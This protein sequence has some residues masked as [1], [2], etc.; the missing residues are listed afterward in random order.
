[1]YVGCTLP[2]ISLNSPRSL[3]PF[4][5]IPRR[6]SVKVEVV[7][8]I[9]QSLSLISLSSGPI[10]SFNVSLTGLMLVELSTT[11]SI[12]NFFTST[13]TGKTS[14]PELFSS[15][16]LLET[17]FSLSSAVCSLEWGTLPSLVCSPNCCVLHEH[18]RAITE[19]IHLITSH[20]L[21]IQ[22]FH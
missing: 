1:M 6:Q 11:I 19:I 7:T 17:V 3:S 9:C 15:I 10:L 16:N 20:L 22:L 14:N 4:F 21:A 2:R 5:I 8:A 12:S 18:N 13:A